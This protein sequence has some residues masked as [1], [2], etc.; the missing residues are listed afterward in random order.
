MIYDAEESDMGP[1]DEVMSWTTDT[2]MTFHPVHWRI[3]V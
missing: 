2:K 1:V 3:P